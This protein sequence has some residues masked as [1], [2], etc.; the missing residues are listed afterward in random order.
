MALITT[1]QDQNGRIID[2]LEAENDDEG[3]VA[4]HGEFNCEGALT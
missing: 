1:E 2:D 4:D 3:T